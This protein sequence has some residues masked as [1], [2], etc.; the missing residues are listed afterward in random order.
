MEMQE[1]GWVWRH[2][3]CSSRARA[4]GAFTRT[5]NS[6]RRSA[7]SFN[8]GCVH[9]SGL[10]YVFSMRCR[11]VCCEICSAEGRL[12]FRSSEVV[13]V[14]EQYSVWQPLDLCDLLDPL[15]KPFQL[16]SWTCEWLGWVKGSSLFMATA[17]G[18]AKPIS[19]S[20]LYCFP[21]VSVWQV[22]FKWRKRTQVKAKWEVHWFF[23]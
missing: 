8:V 17:F 10:P 20:T 3:F 9:F 21:C 22:V 15:K 12:R 18:V 13:W 14:F 19:S 2:F 11:D 6:L 7:E 23:T 5:P 4:A 16:A 1:L